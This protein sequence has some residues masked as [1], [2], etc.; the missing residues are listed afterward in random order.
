M[1][2][3]LRVGLLAG[4]VCIAWTVLLYATGQSPFGPKRL[5]TIF[6]APVA[7]VVAQWQVRKHHREQASLG[8]Q[9]LV[10]LLAVGLTAALSA[11]GVYSVARTGGEPLMRQNLAEATQIVRA[12]RKQFSEKE[13]SQAAYEANLRS[14]PVAA[15]TAQGVANE[16]FQKK[17]IAGLLIILPG[18]IFLRR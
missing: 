8:R 5:M 9:L 10:G 2:T 11:V 16:D 1:R 12:S 7:A 4:A 17:L 13:L 3:A 15:G 14:L 6:V 18:A